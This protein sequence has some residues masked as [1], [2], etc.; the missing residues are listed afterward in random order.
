MVFAV[1]TTSPLCPCTAVPHQF[2]PQLAS[3]V[4]DGNVHVKLA[5]ERAMMHAL[6]IHTN[7]DALGVGYYADACRHTVLSRC[8]RPAA[9]VCTL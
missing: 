7:A 1:I 9:N 6:Q 2:V 3:G 5:A 4:R 8:T